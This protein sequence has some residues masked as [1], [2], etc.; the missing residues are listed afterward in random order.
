MKQLVQKSYCHCQKLQ[1]AKRSKLE[2]YLK[3]REIKHLDAVVQPNQ[4]LS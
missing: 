2:V 3:A 4:Q 1:N